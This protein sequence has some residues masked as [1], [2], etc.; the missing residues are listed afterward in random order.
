MFEARLTQVTSPGAQSDS[1]KSQ[2]KSSGHMMRVTLP[3]TEASTPKGHSF[4]SRHSQSCQW[5]PGGC[6]L[7]L[8][9]KHWALLLGDLWMFPRAPMVS[10]CG[11]VALP[12]L[13]LP[14]GSSF[15]E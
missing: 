11:L 12:I 5:G 2:F 1:S 9:A 7:G 13:S 6:T 8:W 10:I 4:Y 14:S 15:E 3:L